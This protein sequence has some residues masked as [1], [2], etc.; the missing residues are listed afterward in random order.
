MASTKLIIRSDRKDFGKTT[1]YIQYT[2]KSVKKKF[3]TGLSIEPERW[4]EK[5]SKAI[6][7]SQEVQEFNASL[8]VSKRRI[9]KIMQDAIIAGEDP[10]IA[11]VTERLKAL[12]TPALVSEKPA[13]TEFLDVY[14]QLIEA[15]TATKAQGTIRHYKSSLNHLKTYGLLRQMTLT[16]DSITTAF[17]H[18]FV[19]YL[20]TDLEMTNGTV[21]N[22][23]KRLK[24]VMAYALDQGLTHNIAFR[25]FK[26]LQH[27]EPDV[28][29]LT[30]SEL[31]T[32]VATD[33]TAVPKL[34]RVRDLFILAC[35]TGLRQSDFSTISP[36]SVD[37]DQLVLRTV[38]TR[39]WLRIPLNQ[40]S[41]SVLER[42]P[43]GLPK[44]SQQK[45]NDF[46]KE[47]GKHCGIDK[48][49][50]VVHYRGSKR[51]EERV[52]KYTLLSSHT[53]R[54]TFVTQCI[55]RG[56]SLEM[57]REFTG[58]K[59]I[60]ALL[61]YAKIANQHKTIQMEKAWG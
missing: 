14:S 58:H 42:Y 30:Q 37:N 20:T 55:E 46:V 3:S 19:T 13:P 9:D 40:Y 22:Q 34:A 2:H 53:G 51:I 61:R 5:S 35:T 23:L 24:V 12:S 1:I 47:L 7:T 33:L 57:I 27:T 48:P 36:D 60:S 31:Q 39:S 25:K 26:A 52:P 16:F 6:G 15:T 28:V 50:L 41:R 8:Q 49:T 17:Y 44:L 10:T 29:Y 4:N 11:L 54:R 38:K 32:L 59:D 56:M 43:D 18:D 21:N 45:F